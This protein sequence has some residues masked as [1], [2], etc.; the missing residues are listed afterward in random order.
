V[1]LNVLHHTSAHAIPIVSLITGHANTLSVKLA[2]GFVLS[3]LYIPF[4]VL[5][6]P[7]KSLAH[8]YN[9]LSHSV[10]SVIPLPF[11]Y[12][13][14]FAVQ[15]PALTQLYFDVPVFASVCVN[16]IPISAFFHVAELFVALIVGTIVSCVLDN[17]VAT[18]FPF[19]PVSFA[20]HHH[21]F[22]VTCH[23]TLGVTTN[24]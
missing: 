15:S 6:F 18:M 3:N 21:T 19:P 8:K 10:L 11:G 23:C 1:K 14:P 22:T 16:T 12:T 17:C 7:A 20:A 5:L 9:V 13:V 4:H 2:V 24:V